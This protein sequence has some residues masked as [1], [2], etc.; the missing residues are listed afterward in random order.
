MADYALDL[1]FFRQLWGGDK[2][3]VPVPPDNQIV[4]LFG[5]P[6]NLGNG[7]E[8]YDRH[9]TVE[10]IQQQYND[11]THSVGQVYYIDPSNSMQTQPYIKE[12]K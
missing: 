5:W 4:Y 3:N 7:Q 12:S 6:M 1:E 11:F 10:G 2:A 8:F 9:A